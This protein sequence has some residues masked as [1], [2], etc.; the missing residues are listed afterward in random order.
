MLARSK[1]MVMSSSTPGEHP[2]ARECQAAMARAPE[3][4]FQAHRV[5]ETCLHFTDAPNLE[6][7]TWLPLPETVRG[8]DTWWHV[9]SIVDLSDTKEF[10]VWC[11]PPEPR[12]LAIDERP[13][14]AHV[15]PKPP[16]AVPDD[17]RALYRSR[18]QLDRNGL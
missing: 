12:R 18:R 17:L 5:S 1:V 13:Q 4:R 2:P 8:R 14:A 3:V 16:A 10:N 15:E 11:K 6:R 7:L 9:G